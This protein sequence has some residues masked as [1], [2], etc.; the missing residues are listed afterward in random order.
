MDRK[1]GQPRKPSLN[2]LCS[3][4]EGLLRV[5]YD[6]AGGGLWDYGA[7]VCLDLH[8]PKAPQGCRV[9]IASR[10]KKVATAHSPGS[11]SVR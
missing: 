6:R 3:L 1:I 8:D 10:R 9:L 7:T 4:E 5:L 2:G 11:P